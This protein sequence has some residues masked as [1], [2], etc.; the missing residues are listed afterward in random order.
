MFRFDVAVIGGGPAG[1]WTAY[2]LARAGARV[3]LVD[4]SHP[5]EK[6]CGGGVTGRALALVREAV[7]A[8]MFATV[9]IARS[10]FA[11]RGASATCVLGMARD[12]STRSG[13]TARGPNGHSLV[14]V[15]RRDFDSALFAAAVRAGAHPVR[16]RAVDLRGTG[17][18]WRVSTRG[19]DLEAEWIVGADGANSLVRRRLARP[20]ERT[21]LSIATGYFVHEVE[22]P[23]AADIAVEFVDRPAGYLW[24]FPRR[25]HLAV[26]ICAQADSSTA[27]ALQ[28]RA[29]AWIAENVARPHRLER[30]SWPIP[31]LSD[32]ALRHERAGGSGWLLVGDAAGLVD[33]IT[34]EGIYFALR[35]AADAA[36]SLLTDKDPTL[37]YGTR[38]REDVYAELHRAARLKARFYQPRFIGLLIRGLGRSA[39]IRAVMADLVAGRQT[40]HGLRRRLF[41]TFEWRL[42]AELFGSHN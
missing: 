40:Y 6:P 30:Y 36:A 7:D 26:G 28:A 16:A 39:A 15:S 23:S 5:R 19:E 31:T 11:Y 25:D 38:L 14:V 17:R 8:R 35:S 1:A 10:S 33:P 3:A 34:R 18:C 29:A 20:F 2:R 24:S 4:G 41:A 42:M 22:S 21:D 12:D 9:G 27:P 37:G 32:A 13:G